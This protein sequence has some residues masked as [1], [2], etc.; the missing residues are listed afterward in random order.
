MNPIGFVPDMIREER[1]FRKAGISFGEKET[2][3]IFNALKKFNI[4]RQSCT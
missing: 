4:A 1:M 3:M 2:F